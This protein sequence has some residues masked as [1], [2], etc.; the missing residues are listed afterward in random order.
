MVPNELI[1]LFLMVDKGLKLHIDLHGWNGFEI[2][3]VFRVQCACL[4]T[5]VY[6]YIPQVHEV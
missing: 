6:V 4:Y 3:H 2:S 1:K 5:C